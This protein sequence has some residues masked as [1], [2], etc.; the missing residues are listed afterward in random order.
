M[1][2]TYQAVEVSAP[3]VLRVV[4]R[5]IREPG[6]AAGARAWVDHSAVECARGAGLARPSTPGPGRANVPGYDHGGHELGLPARE[7]AAR[8]ANRSCFTY[9]LRTA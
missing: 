4:E 6:V 7:D 5:P 1:A 9:A 3:G 8:L 2:D